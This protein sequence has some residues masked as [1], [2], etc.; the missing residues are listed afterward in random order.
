GWSGC[1]RQEVS[2][3]AGRA[4]PGYL[5]GRIE[6]GVW[7]V[8]LGLYEVADAG[9][10]VRLLI[11]LRADSLAGEV[12]AEVPVIR[13]SQPP[14]PAAMRLGGA[15]P[16]RRWLAGELHSHTEHS[17]APGS[18]TALI[19]AAEN[20]GLDFL[21]V[22][23]HNTTSHLPELLAARTHLLLVP[24]LELTTYHGHLNVW[25]V[26][27]P[28]DFRCESADDLGLVASAAGEG[29]VLSASHPFAPG[30]EWRFGYQLPLHGL[31]VWHGP[32]VGL[33]RLSYEVWQDLLRQ[34]RRVFALAG[35]D[36]HTGKPET[37]PPG[38]PVTWLLAEPSTAGILSA[39]TGGRVCLAETGNRLELSLR[40]GSQVW[41]VGDEAPAGLLR[42]SVRGR[43]SEA[44][45]VR[46]WNGAGI[47]H[48]RPVGAGA[49]AA[50][51]ELHI[52]ANDLVRA[53]LSRP[54]LEPE[55]LRFPLLALTNPI[56]TGDG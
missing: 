37:L 34:G 21:A 51:L 24:G 23:D 8:L 42:V 30:M 1:A 17:D 32:C 25:G 19:A 10:E 14:A 43:A 31:E 53:D 5:P 12:A 46:V 49:F 6:P 39:L 50:E 11:S 28:L 44:G 48:R 55:L 13:S 29:C 18:L 47:V 41:Q 54:D 9:L 45:E 26:S 35:A 38:T 7:H 3:A 56:W 15:R 36:V 2:V 20:A 4:T 16:A 40:R 22:T 27:Q 52:P 33:N